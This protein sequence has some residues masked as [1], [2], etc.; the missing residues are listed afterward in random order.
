MWR[1]LALAFVLMSS[2][3]VGPAP[4][5]TPMPG[6]GSPMAPGV[7]AVNTGVPG[8]EAERPAAP[9]VWGM[10]ILCTLVILFIVCKP[11]RKG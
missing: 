6:T 4:S 1:S 5:Q 8:P 2:L 7:P 10:A 11:S 3:L 9:M